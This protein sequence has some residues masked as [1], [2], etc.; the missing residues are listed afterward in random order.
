M[1]M[2]NEF[3]KMA[4]SYTASKGVQIYTFGVSPYFATDAGKHNPAVVADDKDVFAAG[5]GF[6]SEFEKVTFSRF[7]F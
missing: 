4:K 1:G 2:M 7:F 6:D 5:E 3:P